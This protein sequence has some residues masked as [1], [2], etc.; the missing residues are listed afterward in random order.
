MMLV[1]MLKS[2]L[3]ITFWVIDFVFE[4]VFAINQQIS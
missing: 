1:S 3:D 4:L 2:T